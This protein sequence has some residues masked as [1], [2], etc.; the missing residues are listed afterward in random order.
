[1]KLITLSKP[2]RNLSKEIFIK[3]LKLYIKGIR[4]RSTTNIS[5][6]R[7]LKL[8]TIIQ[9]WSY[10]YFLRR[11]TEYPFSR[12]CHKLDRRWY[13][14]L[15]IY[16]ISIHHQS[17]DKTIWIFWDDPTVS[18]IRRVTDILLFTT[19]RVLVRL[20]FTI[21]STLPSFYK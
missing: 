17:V 3:L 16:T 5:L 1:M 18:N 20:I 15:I 2:V 10:L 8:S 13:Y 7:P 4:K 19:N 21:F 11:A 12:P 6:M 14:S 9:D